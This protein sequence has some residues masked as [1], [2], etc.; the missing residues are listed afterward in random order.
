MKY[1]EKGAVPATFPQLREAYLKFGLQVE[2]LP[3]GY[4]S[5]PVKVLH[6]GVPYMLEC[7]HDLDDVPTLAAKFYV[8]L[9][10]HHADI[11]RL[12][13]VWK[14]LVQ[15]ELFVQSGGGLHLQAHFMAGRKMLGTLGLSHIDDGRFTGLETIF[16]DHGVPFKPYR[17]D[18]SWTKGPLT[19]SASAPWFT[20]L[21]DVD[22]IELLCASTHQY[23][24]PRP[25]HDE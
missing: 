2:E 16:R 3:I 1:Y 7:Y 19:L 24:Y 14:G 17:P 15:Q 8:V 10:R 5:A 12:Y 6:D 13:E 9:E 4:G 21:P 20:K 11:K 25:E 23:R 22:N 18:D